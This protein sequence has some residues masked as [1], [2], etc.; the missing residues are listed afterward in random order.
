MRDYI[1]QLKGRLCSWDF[2]PHELSDEDLLRC[3]ALIFEDAMSLDGLD[4]LYIPTRSNSF[5]ICL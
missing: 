2:S 5:L 3:V 1:R 4:D